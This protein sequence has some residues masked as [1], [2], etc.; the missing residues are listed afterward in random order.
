MIQSSKGPVFISSVLCA[1]V[2][3]ACGGQV[4]FEEQNDGGSGGSGTTGPGGSTKATTGTKN[5]GS[6]TG[7]TTN[8]Q[9]SSVSSTMTSGGCSVPVPNPTDCI[10][11][12]TTVYACGQTF[13]GGGQQLCPSFTP[14]IISQDQ[15]LMGCIQQC[16]NQM[17]L[18]QIVD[19]NKCDST[20]QTLIGVSPD[21][22]QLCAGDLGG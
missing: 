7:P 17:A 16:Q 11:A 14:N 13:C 1:A 19:P 15:F 3:I 21:F 9:V 8:N 22:A 5:T 20:I 10:Q 18:I 6:T 2:A 12:C 4:V